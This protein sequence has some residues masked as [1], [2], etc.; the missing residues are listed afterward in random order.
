PMSGTTT[1]LAI[2]LLSVIQQP[3]TYTNPVYPHDFPDP[4]VI[5]AGDRYFAFGTQARG[6][7]FQL[8]ESAD[9]VHWTP[10]ALELPSPWA[11][12][13]YWAP[14]VAEHQGKYYL[15]Y[16]ALDPESRKH[17]VA[18][19]TADAPTGPFTHRAILVRGDN[20]RVGVIDATLVFDDGQPYLI[21]SEED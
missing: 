3:A 18:I 19:A 17:H 2:G 1:I 10:R 13:H 4:H 7:G 6:T 8:L 14:E 9:L 5:R 21:Y 16:S 11:R 12:D 20:N 15:T